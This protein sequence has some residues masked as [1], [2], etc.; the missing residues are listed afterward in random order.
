MNTTAVSVIMPCYNAALHVATSISSVQ[1]QTFA[2][3]TLIAVD[4]G[5]TDRTADVIAAVGDPRVQLIRQENAG[6]STARNR[7]LAEVRSPYVAFLDADDTWKPAFL[8]ELTQ[9]LAGHPE[10]ALAYCG[11]EDVPVPPRRRLAHSPPDYEAA[12][13]KIE[14]LLQGCPWVIHAA[15]A[16]TEA[17]RAAG[18]FDSGFVV[19]EDYLLWLR[20]AVT[21][22]LIRV[23][24]ILAMYH[25][26]PGRSQATTDVVRVV[27]QTRQAVA[28]F[29]S[30]QPEIA[31]RIGL[32]RRREL[33]YGPGLRC[34]YQTLWSRN[35]SAAQALFRD[36]LAAGYLGWRDV[37]YA[38]PALLPE[39]A[40]R[41]LV[42]SRD[43]SP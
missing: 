43:S 11:W 20:L 39:L 27:R 40:Y 15:L 23:P 25:H 13:D 42:R 37:K 24:R 7:G 14:A 10:A 3:W 33:L 19:A 28:V 2:D 22:R 34:A 16:R 8:S 9:A 36:A 41:A 18:G 6:A 35:L 17:V 38:L 26:D 31:R 30:E 29:L 1:R 5:S 12:T 32:R 4:D 21:G